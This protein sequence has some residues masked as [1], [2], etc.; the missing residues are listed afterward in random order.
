MILLMICYH[1]VHQRRSLGFWNQNFQ[2]FLENG[3]MSCDNCSCRRCQAS[4]MRFP[5]S[6]R[7]MEFLIN[8][9]TFFFGRKLEINMGDDLVDDMI[10]VLTNHGYAFCLTEINEIDF[11]PLDVFKYLSVSRYTCLAHIVQNNVA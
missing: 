7:G 11:R 5:F 9:L 4:L 2:T 6:C 8:I 1:T 10:L 3:N